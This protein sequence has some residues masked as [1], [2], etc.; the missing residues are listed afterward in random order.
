MVARGGASVIGLAA[1]REIGA[2]VAAVEHLNIH[3]LAAAVPA[4][5]VLPLRRRGLVVWAAGPWGAA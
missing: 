4:S 1:Y 5:L 2:W 3:G